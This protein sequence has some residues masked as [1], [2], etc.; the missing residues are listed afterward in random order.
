MLARCCFTGNVYVVEANVCVVEANVYVV[1]G[2]L[3]RR[4]RSF[5]ALAGSSVV[6]RVRKRA[7]LPASPFR[8]CLTTTLKLLARR[9]IIIVYSIFSHF[10]LFPMGEKRL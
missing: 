2:L 6:F 7:P 10:V 9:D 5:R 8:R 3:L 1:E 4:L